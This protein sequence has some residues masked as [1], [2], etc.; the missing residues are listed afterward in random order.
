[1]IKIN[2][3]IKQNL[4]NNK[5]LTMRI[6][7]IYQRVLEILMFNKLTKIKK[8]KKSILQETFSKIAQK[9]N[10]NKIKKKN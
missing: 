9:I 1:M 7:K 4:S 2:K 6:T 10:Y 3:N 5:L 8:L